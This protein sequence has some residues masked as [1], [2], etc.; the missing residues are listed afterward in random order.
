VPED[1]IR[2]PNTNCFSCNK[3]IYRRPSEIKNG[4]IFCSQDCYGK[5]NRKEVSCVMCG[6]PIPARKNAKTCS[7]ACANKNRIGMSYKNNRPHDIVK[8]QRALKLRLLSTR[9][10]TCERCKYSKIEILQVHH[11]DRDRD[12]NA[13]SN[14]ELI[15]PNCHAEEH[16]LEKSWLSGTLTGA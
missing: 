15:C 16:Y 1:Y 3:A 9:G 6:S 11:R 14:L 8:N 2:N 13:L 10:H 5:A 4:R 7:R 12:N